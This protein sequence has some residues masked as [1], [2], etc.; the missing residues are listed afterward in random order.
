MPVQNRVQNRCLSKNRRDSRKIRESARIGTSLGSRKQFGGSLKLL[1]K[2]AV[3]V[4]AAMLVAGGAAAD[5]GPELVQVST[6]V[7]QNN[8]DFSPLLGTYSYEVSWQGIPAASAEI[9]LEKDDDFYHSVIT[10]KTASGIDL[11]YRLRFRAESFMR[12]PSFA[13]VRSSMEQQENSREK[14]MTISYTSS[15]DIHVVKQ[16]KGKASSTLRFNPQN[17]TLDPF[18][19]AFLARSLPW[20]LGQSREFDTFTGKTRY[21][22]TLTAVDH[23][24]INV[25]GLKRTAWVIEPEVINL[26]KS[27]ETKEKKLHSAKIYISDDERRDLLR[28]ESKVFVGTVTT[29]LVGFIPSSAQPSDAQFAMTNK[30]K[31]VR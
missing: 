29:E 16:Q 31:T 9:T 4:S 15:G 18:S 30:N 25:D 8:S 24:E 12:A 13:P 20:Q 1:K 22:I 14:S 3:G 27:R 2:I 10:A 5:T 21:L 11:L 26:N 19:A 17:F 28:V 7:Y 6:P 23:R